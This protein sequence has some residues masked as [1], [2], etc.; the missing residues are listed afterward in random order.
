[1]RERRNQTNTVFQRN[2]G[3]KQEGWRDGYNEHKGDMSLLSCG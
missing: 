1:M 3:G 2:K